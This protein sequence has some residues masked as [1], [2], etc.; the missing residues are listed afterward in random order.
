MAT[1][2][3]RL[4][5]VRGPLLPPKAL[6]EESEECLT[7]DLEDEDPAFLDAEELCSGGVKAGSLPG[8]LR[9]E[10]AP[11]PSAGGRPPLFAGVLWGGPAIS[12]HLG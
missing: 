10:R 9:G 4:R 7:E 8:C 1:C 5:E 2:S 6:V 12:A 3:A 11:G